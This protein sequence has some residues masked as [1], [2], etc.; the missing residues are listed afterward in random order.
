M[1]F[2][3]EAG[4]V[5]REPLPRGFNFRG[6]VEPAAE[7]GGWWIQQAPSRLPFLPD[8]NIEI[9]QAAPRGRVARRRDAPRSQQ[10]QKA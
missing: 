3:D 10:D 7:R 1:Q 8:S 4:D 5:P 6:Q 9:G 2:E